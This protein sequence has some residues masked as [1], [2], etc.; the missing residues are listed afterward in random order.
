[1]ENALWAH[2]TPRRAFPATAPP[3]GEQ[4]LSVPLVG[5]EFCRLPANDDKGLTPGW[6]CVHV[7]CGSVCRVITFLA[8]P[9]PPS[10]SGPCKAQF[11]TSYNQC[12]ATANGKWQGQLFLLMTWC[13]FREPLEL[14]A[15]GFTQAHFNYKREKQ[16]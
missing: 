14:C 2:P 6:A 7:G 1:M 8:P 3:H 15:L 10:P 4:H 11:I 12:R 16:N 13:L 9:P 5:L